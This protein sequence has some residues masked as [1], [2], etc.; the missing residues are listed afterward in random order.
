MIAVTS[1]EVAGTEFFEFR[2]TSSADLISGYNGQRNIIYGAEGND[3][4]S[5]G[6]HTPQ[7]LIFGEGGD[8]TLKGGLV[9]DEL[10]GGSGADDMRGGP[11]DDIYYVDDPNDVVFERTRWEPV[12]FGDTI[13]ASL[14]YSLAGLAVEALILDSIARIGTGNDLNN[15]VIGTGGDH[16]LDGG[17]GIDTLQGGLGDDTYILR[18]ADDIAEEV[19]GNAR[20]KT[21]RAEEGGHDTVLA[22]NSYKLMLGIEDII[23]QD[24]LGKTGNPVNNLTAIGNNLD[25]LVQ[26]NSTDNSLNG[27][28]GNDTLTGG[29]GADDFIFS[30]TLGRE[31]ADTI[32]DFTS[33]EDRIVIKAALVNLGTGAVAADAFHLGESAQTA[34]HRFLFD[35][36]TLRYDTDGSGA[37]AAVDVAMFERN[38]TVIA[39]DFFVV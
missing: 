20:Q 6:K 19:G 26:G 16:T 12:G 33:G 23:L 21:L 11:G 27:R 7:Q 15:R 4:L 29:A 10:N 37:G 39:E 3:I 34:D 8:D 38:P 9:G 22:H 18:H 36:T 32:T 14:D 31:H 13:V 24:V 30:D 17:R 1:F 35:G 25:N 5:A 28:T 2:G